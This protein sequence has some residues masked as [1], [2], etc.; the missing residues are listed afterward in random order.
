MMPMKGVWRGLCSVVPPGTWLVP[1][2]LIRESGP[3]ALNPSEKL[4][5]EVKL[6]VELDIFMLLD[7]EPEEP[8]LA[9]EAG[10]RTSPAPQLAAAGPPWLGGGATSTV[11][12]A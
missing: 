2:S 7:G 9:R 8:E 5:L 4:L 11:M 10:C 12:E 6:L 3:W 1:L